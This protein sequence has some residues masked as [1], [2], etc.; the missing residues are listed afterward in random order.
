M[1]AWTFVDRQSTI[2]ARESA[3]NRRHA[4]GKDG[5]GERGHGD[6]RR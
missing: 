3:L 5:I 6:H 1:R 4:T 2:A